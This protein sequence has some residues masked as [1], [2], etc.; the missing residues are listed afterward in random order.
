MLTKKAFLTK[1][2]A[3]AYEESF[4]TKAL[5]GMIMN[6]QLSVAIVTPGAFAVPSGKSSSV[7]QVVEK[8]AERLSRHMRVFVLGRK[9]SSQPAREHRSGVTYL[10]S[11]Y[12]KPSAYISDVSERLISLK[13]KFIQVENR[14]RYVPFL[15]ARHRKARIGLVLHSTCFISKPYITRKELVS[16]LHCS[17]LIIVNSEFLK[18]KLLRKAPGLDDKIVVQHL[19]VDPKQFVSRWSP[20]G[21]EQRMKLVKKLG[22]KH[23]KI[24]LFV[25]RLIEKKGVHHLLLAMQKIREQQPEAMLLVVGGAFYGSHRLTPYVRELHKIG[26]K[27]PEH[28]RFIPYVSHNDIPKWFQLADVVAVPSSGNEAFGLVN[29]E[30]MATGVP[31]VATKAGGMQEIIEHESTGFLIEPDAIDEELAMYLLRIL[32]NPE[33]Q[34]AMGEQGILRV[35]ELFTW[36][37][38]A[39]RRYALYRD[40]GLP[41]KT[42]SAFHPLNEA[43]LSNPVEDRG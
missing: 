20:E 12:P 34:R 29:I 21:N 16:C 37:R 32:D 24:I 36:K 33:L 18:M 1:S 30:A 39:E 26:K 6:K 31:V 7:E 40:Y 41:K 10:R 3:Y 38:A 15:R 42:D 8:T 2:S 28:V 17:D 5:R 25:G 9:T 35:L 19:G 23:R 22:L 13:P 43:A 4:L 11:R 27:M 14:P